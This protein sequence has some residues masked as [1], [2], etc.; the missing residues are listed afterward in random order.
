VA[1]P[2]GAFSAKPAP[3]DK[4]LLQLRQVSQE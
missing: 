1:V 4:L 3:L 2:T